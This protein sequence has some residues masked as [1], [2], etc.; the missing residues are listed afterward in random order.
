MRS[1]ELKS[2]NEELKQKNGEETIWPGV[3]T[4]QRGNYLAIIEEEVSFKSKVKK[5]SGYDCES[6]DNE[7]GEVVIQR[8]HDCEKV[9]D[10]DVD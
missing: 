4:Y 8:A 5:R 2:F 6:G 3:R 7:N 10:L 1:L 9:K